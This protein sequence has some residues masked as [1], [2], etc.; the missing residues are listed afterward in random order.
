MEAILAVFTTPG[1]QLAIE[2]AMVAGILWLFV[3]IRRTRALLH[4]RINEVKDEL[5][6]HETTCAE[7][8]GQ[9]K[10]KLDIED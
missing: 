9:T 5:H 7:R 3:E 6:D 4:D 8:W 1:G 2:M 10:T